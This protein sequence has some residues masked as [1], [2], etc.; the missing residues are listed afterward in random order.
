MTC[1]R[2]GEARSDLHTLAGASRL[3]NIRV[4]FGAAVS[5]SVLPL[6]VVCGS[7]A[8]GSGDGV[9]CEVEGYIS[10]ADYSGKKTHMVLFINGRSVEC[11]P[12]KRALE[13]TY[14]AV[15]PKAAKPFIFLEMRLPGKH[16][17]VNVHPTKQEVGFLHQEHLIEAIRAAVEDKLLTS[18]AKRTYAQALLPGASLVGEAPKELVSSYYRPEKLVRT[19][20]KA[21][22]LHAFLVDDA[23]HKHTTAQPFAGRRRRF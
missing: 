21:Q 7:G 6:D 22:T 1:K 11:K 10:S 5:K 15:L 18:N 4:V 17:D 9:H 16:V 14:A 19:D 12:L 8:E 23:T 3:D 13:T 20:A 2:Q